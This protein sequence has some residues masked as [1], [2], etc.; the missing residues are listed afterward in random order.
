[1]NPNK[2]SNLISTDTPTQTKNLEITTTDFL[3]GSL[4]VLVFLLATYQLVSVMYPDLLPMPQYVSLQHLQMVEYKRE[5]LKQSGA[6]YILS[7]I[8]LVFLYLIRK[9]RAKA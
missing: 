1:M 4:S 2:N 7:M 8:Y 6:Y 9:I 5:L 3:I